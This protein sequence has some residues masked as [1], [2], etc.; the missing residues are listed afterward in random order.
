MDVTVYFPQ[1]LPHIQELIIEKQLW[2]YATPVELEI[3]RDDTVSVEIASVQAP[4][5]ITECDLGQI[6]TICP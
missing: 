6:Q 2:I 4:A 5:G 1:E 3:L